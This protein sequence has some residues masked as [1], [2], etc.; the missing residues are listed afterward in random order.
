MGRVTVWRRPSPT[1]RQRIKASLHFAHPPPPSLHNTSHKLFFVLKKTLLFLI[2]SDNVRQDF[3]DKASAAL[4][5]RL[6][7]RRYYVG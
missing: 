2:M 3:G 5:V 6:L 1:S 7:P 4:K